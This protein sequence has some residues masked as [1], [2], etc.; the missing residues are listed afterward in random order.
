MRNNKMLSI[1]LLSF[2]SE[3]RL[4]SVYEQVKTVMELEN[5]PF[6]LIIVDDGSKDNSFKEACLLEEI[7]SRVRAI[8]LSRNYTSH[9]ARFAGLSVCKGNCSVGIPDDLQTPLE[10]IVKMYRLWEQGNQIIIP[11]RA[12]RKDGIFSDL[13]SNLYYSIMNLISDVKFPKGG[14]DGFFIDREIIDI[15]NEKIHPINTSTIVEVL[16]LGFDP[17]FIPF[18]RPPS[19][20]KS[21]WTIKKKIKLALDT[22]LSSSSFPIKFITILG[23]ISVI[24]S[25][26]SIVFVVTLKL[27]GN[28]NLF[29]F[30]IPGWTST[31]I[32]IS[33]FSGLILFSL[34]IIAEY[35]W[36]IYEEVKD[37]PGYI[38]KKKN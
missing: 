3:T 18:D 28:Q 34:G 31:F 35:I 24:I 20:A 25:V 2:Y 17:I 11:F 36:R 38:I 19:N 32:L 6:E 23:F 33:F 8:Q 10:V 16:R 7:D 30:V 13:F 15:L 14:A 12:S 37:R 22:I 5:I 29:G 1:T 4:R 9:Y 21:R 27:S 26:I